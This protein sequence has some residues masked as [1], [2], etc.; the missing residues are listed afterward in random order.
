MVFPDLPVTSSPLSSSIEPSV[1]LI[2]PDASIAN[3]AFE[4]T[5]YSVPG[6]PILILALLGTITIPVVPP[7]VVDTVTFLSASDEVFWTTVLD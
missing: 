6:V 5:V 3:S 4:I 7:S 1:R 2:L